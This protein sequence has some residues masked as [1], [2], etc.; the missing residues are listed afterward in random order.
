[1]GLISS[2]GWRRELVIPDAAE[3]RGGQHDVL[4]RLVIGLATLPLHV[5]LWCA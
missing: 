3:K 5:S 4:G 2:L 1:M